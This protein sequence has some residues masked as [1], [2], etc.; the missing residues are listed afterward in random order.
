MFRGHDASSHQAA[1][2]E[3]RNEKA[4][5][6]I[7]NIGKTL[8]ESREDKGGIRLGQPLN[9]RVVP[10]QLAEVVEND[11]KALLARRHLFEHCPH[12][13]LELLGLAPA[14]FAEEHLGVREVAIGGA[15]RHPGELA[16][17][18][19]GQLGEAAGGHGAQRAL[20]QTLL[21]APL[22][23]PD[24]PA[25]RRGSLLGPLARVLLGDP[26]QTHP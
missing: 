3:N 8:A 20:E 24:P 26:V 1:L 5:E 4:L 14:E 7:A 21:G 22:R 9:Q 18:A 11:A 25:R 13:L 6:D 10:R 15:P 23:R 16:H 19:H 17:V 2:F 12:L